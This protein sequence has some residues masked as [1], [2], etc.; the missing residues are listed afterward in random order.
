MSDWL[1][2][3]KE[4]F[5][6]TKSVRR[7]LHE[8]PELTS[9][10]FKTVAFIRKELEKEEIPYENIPDGGVLAWLDGT[11]N[12]LDGTENQLDDKEV[13]G[14][15]SGHISAQQ[16]IGDESYQTVLLRADC[17]ALPIQESRMNAAFPKECVSK[18]SGV[19]HACG[20]DAHTAMLLT[21][22][23]LLKKSRNTFTGRICFL[24]ERGE[25]GGNCIYY[26]LKWLEENNWKIDACYG[27]H[28]DPS[29]NTGTYGVRS[30]CANSGNVNF[31][32]KLIG[33][34]GHGS[35]PDLSNN[36][37]DCFLA[38]GNAL[39]DLRM[40]YIS[41]DTSLTYNIGSVK[42]G[43]KRNIVP[44]TLTFLGT[45][46]FHDR[47][48]G[49]EF[50]K[51]MERMI[52][53]I[54]HAYGCDVEFVEFTG[55]SFPVYNE[56]QTVEIGKEAAIQLVGSENV[57][58][59][60]I[61]MGSESFSSLSAFYPSAF[62]RVGIRNEEKGITVSGHQPEFDIDEESMLYGAAFYAALAIKWLSRYREKPEEFEPFIGNADDFLRAAC[63]PVPQR[64]DG[65]YEKG[66]R[67]K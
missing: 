49:Y 10:E 19:M 34:S 66:Q 62:F 63:R 37:I 3:A 48:A 50:K 4:L 42:S 14:K 57:K 8:N 26:V 35:R 12:Q 36:P 54:S 2:E 18:N 33:K 32:I 44:E 24:F 13:H 11:K 20:H 21:A 9:R 45:V 29:L 65:E 16:S 25:E 28:T 59:V 43:E 41:P 47:N 64:Y 31:E 55:P 53:D 6:Y 61:N 23:R 1:R 60:P 7:L 30:G 46:R 52:L 38:I 58:N 5:S 67:D 17:D 27:L 56:H 40:K 51:N 22:V 39:K 15:E